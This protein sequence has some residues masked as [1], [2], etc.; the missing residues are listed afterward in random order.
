MGVFGKTWPEILYLDYGQDFGDFLLRLD[1]LIR[2]HIE[3][4]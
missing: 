2:G 1:H 3:R 4:S